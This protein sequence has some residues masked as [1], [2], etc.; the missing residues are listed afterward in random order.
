M[1]TRCLFLLCLSGV[2]TLYPR[3]AR[4]EEPVKV[5]ATVPDLGALVSEV[6]GELV[7][8]TVFAKPAEDPHFIEAKPSFIK[9]LNEA[10]LFLYTGMEMEVGYAPVLL[11]SARN[12]RV[13]A[14]ARGNV[15][16][17]RAITPLGVPS[18]PVDRSMGD[19]HGSGN[20][21]YLLDPL[22][23][24]KVALLLRDRLA[25]LRPAHKK[26]I[27]AR[28][29]D[30]RSRVSRAMVGDVLA[31]KYGADFEKLVLLAEH[32]KLA[33]FLDEQGEAQHL[34]GW[35]GAMTPHL[36]A[37]YVDEHDLWL[38]FARRFGLRNVGHLEPVPG[39]PP[40]TKHLGTVVKKVKEENV[41]LILAAPYYDPKHARLVSEKSGARVARLAHQVGAVDGA[42]SYLGVFDA[43][44]RVVTAALG[45]GE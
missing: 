23:G 22:N 10:D 24:L 3:H 7:T 9:A 5:C 19:V 20:P 33:A 40:S 12:A 14:G 6:G 35:L 44:V 43:N 1:F 34:G 28:Y 8:V 16:C 27:E 2:L 38:Y 42:E 32:G 37:K 26:L 17:S 15:D 25:E 13:L 39:V 36:G 45:G 21:H 18:G 31:A 41:R 30:F 29:E 4:G 11:G